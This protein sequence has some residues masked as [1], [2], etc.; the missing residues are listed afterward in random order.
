MSESNSHIKK[1][2]VLV[3]DDDMAIRILARESMEQAGFDV[4]EADNGAQA[5]SVFECLQPDIVL[6][7]I[8]L[9]DMDGFHV[10]ESIRKSPDGD[11]TPV[12][13]ITGADDSDSIKRA[14][15]VGATD[16]ATKPLNWL[17]LQHRVHYI[18][19]ASQ[20][21]KRLIRLNE[22]LTE[23]KE[24]AEAASQAKSDFLANMS[25]EIR[26]PM[27]GVLGMS[28]I[29]LDTDLNL[30]QRD[31]AETVYSSATSLLTVIDDILDFS[32]IQAGS[33]ALE[34]IDFDLTHTVENVSDLLAEK[35]F[36]KGLELVSVIHENVPSL[37]QG[38]PGRLR[39]ILLNITANAIK[40]TEKGEVVLQVLL[41][42]ETEKKAT[43]RFS[44]KDTGIGIS[45]DRRDRLFKPFSQADTSTTRKYGGTGLGLVISKQLA[46]MMGGQIG[47]ESLENK[48]STFWFTAVFKRQPKREQSVF[49]TPEAISGKQI[50]AVDDNE[51][52]RKLLGNF[53][54]SWNCK[55]SLAASGQDALTLLRKA[56][57]AG[58][59]FDL[60]IVD[61]MMPEMDGEALGKFIKNDPDLRNIVLVMLSSWGKHVDA[62]R[63]EEIGFAAYLTKP[64]KRN[65]LF[66]C[67]G[68]LFSGNLNKSESVSGSKAL[69]PEIF[70]NKR[71]TAR[72]L[73]VED[74]PT[75]QKLALRLL[76]KIGCSADIAANGKEAIKALETA[77]YDLVLMDLQMP[78]MDG[79]EATKIIRETSSEVKRHDIPIVAMTAHAMKDHKDRCLDAG[80]DDYIS[81][82]I[83]SEK[84]KAVLKKYLVSGPPN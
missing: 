3:V 18:L 39:Q 72:L 73:V 10:C 47:V 57:K 62:S 22:E 25:H 43:I 60:A 8:S 53:L 29:L 5:L 48:G 52:N 33:L 80:M 45:R 83:R 78:E 26:T 32:K 44:I 82:P 63:M 76:E 59:S 36:K 56:H 55:Y 9:P 14:Y 74:N 70:G 1:P 46:E 20:A 7:D 79:L 50:L 77:S 67:L 12:V 17:I 30:E 54:E 24:A 28:E 6:L 23:A 38:D 21:A 4:E 13:M 64:I 61:Y 16:F 68:K 11:R 66:N 35:A 51:T 27:N 41:D 71:S 34:T 2:L 19:R 49:T 15:E 42:E 81:K 69:T 75:N 84:L 40:F 31:C 65:H 58:T 37:L